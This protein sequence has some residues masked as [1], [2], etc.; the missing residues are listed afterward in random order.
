MS[1]NVSVDG[2]DDLKRKIAQ[3]K[4]NVRKQASDRIVEAGF[5]MATQA[6]RHIQSNPD[7]IRRRGFL[8]SSIQ[9]Y[10]NADRLGAK[11][12]AEKNYAPYVEFGT[13]DL[14]KVS[15]EFRE[16]ALQYK[17]KGIRKVNLIPRPY[18]QPAYFKTRD[19]LLEALKN[20]KLL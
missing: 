8:A 20:M 7:F 17:G 11:V 1:F 14:V 9:T 12:T 4:R 15:P 3:V 16:V 19:E 13:G 10:V 18:M 5:D 6:K 2:F